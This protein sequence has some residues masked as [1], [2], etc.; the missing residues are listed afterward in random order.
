MPG[1]AGYTATLKYSGSGAGGFSTIV[2]YT[3]LQH[4]EASEDFALDMW[5]ELGLTKA[6]LFLQVGD[7]GQAIVDI[8]HSVTHMFDDFRMS[9]L[10]SGLL[11]SGLHADLFYGG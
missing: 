1:F 11:Q 10:S 7:V 3:V 2:S 9:S 4:M 5:L 6:I 8:R